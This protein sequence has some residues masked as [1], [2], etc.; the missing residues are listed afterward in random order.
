VNNAG[1]GSRHTLATVHDSELLR[2]LSVNLAGA[3]LLT[4]YAC[5]SMLLA[6]SG[7]IVQI[8][9]IAAETGFSGLSV[10]GATKAGLVGFTK[11]LARE[12]APLG[13]TVNAVLPGYLETEMTSELP[14]G[15]LEKVKRR[16]A[17]QRLAGVGDVAGVVAMLLGEGGG[18]ISGACITVDAGYTV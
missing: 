10:Y 8:S 9:S 15:E 18:A 4:K 14:A 12:L 7:R 17:G 2:L 13:I 1:I 11:S 3:M 16:S 6:R 5:R